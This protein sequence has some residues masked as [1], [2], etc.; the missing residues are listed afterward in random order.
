[1]SLLAAVAPTRLLCWEAKVVQ[2]MNLAVSGLVDDF[3]YT[4][5]AVPRQNSGQLIRVYTETPLC[6]SCYSH[7]YSV[8]IHIKLM[9]IAVTA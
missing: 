6:F 7:V 4:C 1:M 2:L 3:L 9:L 5:D 8:L